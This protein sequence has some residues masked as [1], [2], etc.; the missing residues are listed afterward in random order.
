MAYQRKTKEEYRIYSNYGYGWEEVTASETRQEAR[1]LL[2][3]Y[4]DNEP[5]YPHMLKMVRVKL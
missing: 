3:D 4:R 1:A 2:K 5:Q